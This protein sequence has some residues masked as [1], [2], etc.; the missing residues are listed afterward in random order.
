MAASR[1]SS[2]ERERERDR[3]IERGKIS[4]AVDPVPS[5]T[6][7]GGWGG[8]TEGG[9]GVGGEGGVARGEKGCADSSE[10]NRQC[11]SKSLTDSAGVRGVEERLRVVRH[12]AGAQRLA[13]EQ[14]YTADAAPAGAARAGQVNKTRVEGVMVPTS[15]SSY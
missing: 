11:N 10:S 12:I 14:A 13:Q 8:G 7:R 5:A 1:P 2:G 3:Q 6:A 9:C 4:G 15:S